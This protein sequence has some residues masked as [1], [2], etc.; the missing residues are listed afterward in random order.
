MR[1]LLIEDDVKI[2]HFVKEGLKQSGFAVDHTKNGNN[3]LH[4]ALTE[5]YDIAIIDIM[6]PDT[7]GL[8]V[9]EELRKNKII[10]PVLILSAKRS[11]DDR[12]KGLQTGG[13]DYLIKPFAFSELLAR[14]QALLRRLYGTAAPGGG[15]FFYSGGTLYP[16]VVSGQNIPGIGTV[17]LTS[18]WDIDGPIFNNSSTVGLVIR[19]NNGNTAAVLQKTVSGSLTVIAKAGDPVPG[20]AS[21]PN[22]YFTDFDDMAQNNNNDFAFLATYTVDGGSTTRAGVFLKPSGGPLVQIAL[23][24]DSLPDVGGGA[25]LC[26]TAGDDIDGPWLNDSGV[27]AFIADCI[28][29]GTRGIFICQSSNVKAIVLEGDTKPGTASTFGND[30]SDPS[31][32]DNGLVTFVDVASPTGV[33][34]NRISTI[35]TLSQ[36]GMIIFMVFA[37]IGA[38]FYL[39]RKRA[40]S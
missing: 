29:G 30:I 21:G 16:I 38:V 15:I 25:T 7:D 28:N 32:S 3:G 37:G 17:I 8:T 23:Y 9:I 19:G 40:E 20:I 22:V 11:T 4:L 33:F 6:L 12:V 31:L 13:D 34:V 18:A 36:W 24:G 27:V 1:L 2:A 39:R 14:V 35:P 26:G 10:V 5:P